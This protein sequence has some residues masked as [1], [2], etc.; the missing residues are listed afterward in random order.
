METSALKLLVL[1]GQGVVFKSPI[2]DFLLTFSR[3]HHLD[4]SEVEKRWDDRVRD[5]A[6]TG[7]M[8]DHELWQELAGKGVDGERASATHRASY[9]AGPAA[10][11]LREWSNVIPIWLLSNHRTHWLI[12]QLDVL[13]VRDCF[14]QLLVSDQTLLVKPDPAAFRQLLRGD[15]APDEILFVDDQQRN[16]EAAAALGLRTVLAE[17]GQAWLGQVDAALS[18]K[19]RAE[20]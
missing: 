5:R 3:E 10:S 6:W 14:Q 11:R 8:D 1:D 9:E 19:A 20:S 18:D 16:I 15:L 4:P 7:A 12:P 17:P 13:G 2:R